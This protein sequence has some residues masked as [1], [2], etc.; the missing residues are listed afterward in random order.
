VDVRAALVDGVPVVCR[1]PVVDS[2]PQAA[3]SSAQIRV[4]TAEDRMRACLPGPAGRDTAG[5]NSLR[6]AP[7]C[8]FYVAAMVR[9]FLA[10][11]QLMAFDGAA[12]ARDGGTRPVT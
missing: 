2:V 6:W 12:Q 10:V 4:A 11:D 9:S 5:E 1:A 3:H 7:R 8:C